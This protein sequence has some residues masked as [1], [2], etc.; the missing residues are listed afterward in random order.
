VTTG[1][2]TS[3][4]GPAYQPPPPPPPPPPPENPP[5]PEKPE[6]DDW[7]GCAAIMA[8]ERPVAIPAID[9]EKVFGEKD[10]P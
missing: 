9:F 7:A 4:A 10:E 8:L 2:G 1:R 6:L 3:N 5:P